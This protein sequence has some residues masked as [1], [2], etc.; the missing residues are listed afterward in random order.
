[1][2][3]EVTQG[4]PANEADLQLK[5]T[6]CLSTITQILL[7]TEMLTTLQEVDS[8]PALDTRPES[9]D[10][11]LNHR[12]SVCLPVGSGGA[13]PRSGSKYMLAVRQCAQ[14][15]TGL[16]SLFVLSDNYQPGSDS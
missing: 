1:M 11:S 12:P 9:S 15:L 14:H 3:L 8:V 4:S 10:I 13:P 16:I 2:S 5:P 6:R 7:S